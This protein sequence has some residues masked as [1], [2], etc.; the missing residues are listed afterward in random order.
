M[1][2]FIYPTVL[3]FDKTDNVYTIL[4]PDLDIVACGETVEDAYLAA[5]DY[6]QSYLEFASK[7]DADLPEATKFED[8]TKLNPQRFVLLADAE[9]S[10][11]LQL[12]KQEE[13]YKNFVKR[14][15]VNSGD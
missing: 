14:Y 2:K 6:L 10:T 7:M 1:K 4:F 11:N 8:A 12:S 15:L 13:G 5:E 9:I 3:F